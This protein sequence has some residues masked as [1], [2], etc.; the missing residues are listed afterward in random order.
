MEFCAELMNT[1]PDVNAIPGFASQSEFGMY[2]IASVEESYNA[3][4]QEIG[5]AE[6]AAVMEAK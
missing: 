2:A 3:I 6:L 5:I 1:T 4:M